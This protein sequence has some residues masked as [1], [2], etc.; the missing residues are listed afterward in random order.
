M[1]INELIMESKQLDEGPIAQAI[2]KGAGKVARGVANIG[3]DLKTGFKAGYGGTNAAPAANTAD[4]AATTTTQSVAKSSGGSTID[5]IKKGMSQASG[6]S[7]E[8]PGT[9]TAAKPAAAA[10]TAPTAQA[11]PTPAAASDDKVMAKLQADFE[12]H[13]EDTM[14]NLTTLLRRI[15]ALEKAAQSVSASAAND[16]AASDTAATND[17]A[18]TTSDTATTTKKRGGKVAGELSQTDSA[19]RRRASRRDKKN[20]AATTGGA[21]AFNQMTNQVTKQNSSIERTGSSLAE[22]LAARVAYYANK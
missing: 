8:K 11:N 19:V 17:T 3:K 21:G 4:P 6:Q 13:K 1:K 16:T 9:D 14:T 10:D 22:S 5:Q 15:S 7:T 2:G 20:A 12:K 18:V